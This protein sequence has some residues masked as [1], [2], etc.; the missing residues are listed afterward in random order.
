[1]NKAIVMTLIA[2]LILV[3]VPTEQVQAAEPKRGSVVLS[4]IMPG[5]GEWLNRDFEGSF[6]AV[7]CIL[8]YVCCFF[9]FSSALD[10]AAGDSSEKIRF[11]F[12]SK[13]VAEQSGSIGGAKDG[14]R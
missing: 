5:T 11:D 7:E 14:V 1:M 9:T 6:P 13:P 10:A 4:A 8:G 2:A 12:W 3:G